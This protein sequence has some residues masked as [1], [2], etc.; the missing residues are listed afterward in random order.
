MLAKSAAHRIEIA[1]HIA[2]EAAEVVV[3]HQHPTLPS[4]NVISPNLDAPSDGAETTRELDHAIERAVEFIRG[5]QLPS[6][7]WISEE[8]F[9]PRTS[10]VHL[11]TLAFVDRLPDVDARG[12]ARFLATVQLPDGS[13][14]AYPFSTEGELCSTALAYAALSLADLPEQARAR[15][16][17]LAFIEQ[18][19]G[20]D[21]VLRRLND[22]GDLTA[23]YLAMAG[24]IDPFRLPDP[25]LSLMVVP[26][27]LKLVLRKINAGVIE[28]MVF[29]AS[30]TRYLRRQRKP[31]SLLR[32]PKHALEAKRCLEFYESWLN[33]N[34]NNNGTTVQTDQ[35]IAT[36]VALGRSPESTSVYS[37]ISWFDKHKIWEEDR[38]HLRAFFNHNWMTS[39]C[40]R[41][42][43]FAGVGREDPMLHDALDFLCWSQS[44]LPM[45]KLNLS[46]ADAH[47]TGG[48]GFEDDNLILPDMDDTGTVLGA[49]GI[50]LRT[51]DNAALG[52]KRIAN[53]RGAI[54]TG[55]PNLLDMQSDNGGWAGFVWNLGDKPAG[56]IFDEPIQVP[57]TTAEK[58]GFLLRP[59]V[60][61]GEPAVSGLTGR[62]L[63]GLGGLGYRA[64]SPAVQNAARFLKN[65]QMACG[66]WWGRW[67]VAYLPATACALSGLADC[68]W[69]MQ[70][71]WLLKAVHW[72]LSK[73]NDDGGWGETPAAYEDFEQA[74]VG[75]SM[76]PL[77]GHVLIGL[78]D[79]G[80]AEHPAVERGIEYLLATQSESGRWPSNDWLQ[81][82]EPNSTYYFYDGAAWY[83]PLEALA[84][85]RRA[86]GKPSCGS[87][88]QRHREHA[89][90]SGPDETS[91]VMQGDPIADDVIRRIVERNEQSLLRHALSNIDTLGSPLPRSLPDPAREFFE[92]TQ[93]LPPWA[94]PV[95]IARGQRLFHRHTWLMSA[96]L[97][98]SSLPQSYA[99][100][101]GA[102][103]L[104]Q[105]QGMT[106]NVHQRVLNTGAF[107]FDVCEQ[108][109]LSPRGRGI[110]SAQRVRL[111]HA[112][113]RGMLHPRTGWSREA[114]GTPINQK[115]LRG[116]ML[117]FSIVLLDALEVAGVAVDPADQHAFVHLW[118]VVAHVLGLRDEHRIDSVA[119]AYEAA[120][121]ER[122]EG[123]R[124]SP[125]GRLLTER[126]VACMR[127]YF[128]GKSV[129]V[130][131][132]LIRFFS[133]DA[134]ADLL[135]VPKDPV[136]RAL[137]RSSVAT[138]MFPRLIEPLVQSVAGGMAKR[139][140]E[141]QRRADRPGFRFVAGV[142]GL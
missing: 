69:N 111:H 101:D 84:K 53:V 41:A 95:L 49:L 3:Q 118:A 16:N 106:R 76:P 136:G 39:L 87:P 96:G 29:V 33:P 24:L 113:V 134:C 8:Y 120:R 30:V 57:K 73:Q 82:Y 94:D 99:S 70:E 103:V 114:W 102:R 31:T 64:S 10:A 67:F 126:L 12:Y 55:L 17:A 83:A 133:G 27:A 93:A 79:A 42:L 28:V 21:A 116:T 13:F 141:A 22:A 51:E 135:G 107:L 86:L 142:L 124:A 40:L 109:G 4:T 9:E 6:G 75:P 48:W 35:A 38:L 85:Y 36:L 137:V 72:L 127:H 19:G 66:A 52:R 37:A 23:V 115:H 131:H 130:P 25:D 108:G 132:A 11:I 123:W 78:I 44:K 129:R 2:R 15:A 112:V 89:L 63:Q 71:P 105:S 46:R 65:Q 20:F 26:G 62:V 68:G 7:A 97:L 32:L 110:R 90:S 91:A 58:L 122:S 54:D 81:V 121:L 50:A 100:A 128:P 45:P 74:G 60:E 5:E 34:G 18:R 104:T 56:P 77:T 119:E 47:R 125:Q 1:L 80:L 117:T 88:P 61:L 43:V 139:L 98:C 92:T 140:L 59:P 14:P 138:P